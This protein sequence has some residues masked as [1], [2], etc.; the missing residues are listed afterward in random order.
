MSSFTPHNDPDLVLFP[1]LHRRDKWGVKGLRNLANILIIAVETL[2]FD[3]MQ[4]H[5]RTA[6]DHQTIHYKAAQ[7]S[8]ERKSSKEIMLVLTIS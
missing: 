1:P 5:S 4:S 8:G 2:K 6:S 7:Q 3:S